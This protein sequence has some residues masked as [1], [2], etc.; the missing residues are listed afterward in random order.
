MSYAFIQDV[1]ADAEMYA[2]IRAKLGDR[3]PAGLVAHLAIERNG[4]LRYVDVWETEA[5]W[6][7]FH[8]T[9]LWPVV[10]EVLADY[11]I[12]V[13]P[14]LVHRET[15]NAIDAWVATASQPVA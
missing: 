12:T 15:I 8:D 1:P 7:D 9:T 11:G 13:D 2:K 3:P 14:S 5:H 6:N 10:T 4:G